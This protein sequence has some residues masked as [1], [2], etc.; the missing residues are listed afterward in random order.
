MKK[1]LAF[2]LCI[3][4]S[5]LAWNLYQS[6]CH[7]YQATF[8]LANNNE[9]KAFKELQIA[10]KQS[11]FQFIGRFYLA[12]LYSFHGDPINA[13]WLYH[14][15]DLKHPNFLL[16]NYHR[17]LLY[18]RLGL[19]KIAYEELCKAEKLYPLDP[20]IREEKKKYVIKRPKQ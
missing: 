17:A 4:L 3:Y 1:S 10:V 12:G 16:L 2:A 14:E 8:Y 15:L 7:L 6:H 18:E 19:Y 5:F 11:P 13:L 9:P 20:V